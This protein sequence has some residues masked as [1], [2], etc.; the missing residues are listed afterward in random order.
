MARTRTTKHGQE[1]GQDQDKDNECKHKDKGNGK[2][3]VNDKVNIKDNHTGK[4][5]NKDSDKGKVK[6]NDKVKNRT[7]ARAKSRTR[8]RPTEHAACLKQRNQF[9]NGVQ[10]TQNVQGLFSRVTQKDVSLTHRARQAGKEDCRRGP[11]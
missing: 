10:T 1:L 5:K 6:D 11:T 4:V 3:K 9:Y 2:D 7:R 8:P